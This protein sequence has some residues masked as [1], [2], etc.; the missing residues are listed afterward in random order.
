MSMPTAKQKYWSE[1]LLLAESFEGSLTQYAQTQNVPV[2][3]LYYWRSYF[4]RAV[5]EPKTKPL[6]TQVVNASV[7]NV[8][9]KLQIGK[10]QIQFTQL[11]DPQWLSEFIAAS[12]TS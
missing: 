9:L 2:Q 10:T 11:P 12:H 5:V 8:C 6:F 4:K 7:T 1:Q 3:S